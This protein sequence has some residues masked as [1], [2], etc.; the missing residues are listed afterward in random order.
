MTFSDV[1]EFQTFKEYLADSFTSRFAKIYATKLKPYK[2]SENILLEQIYFKEI[3]FLLDIDCK[4]NLLDDERYFLFYEKIKDPYASFT[5]EDFITFKIFHSEV[6]RL[7]KEILS[8]KDIKELKNITSKIYSFSDIIEYINEKIS[9]DARI[10]DTASDELFS[11]REKLKSVRGEITNSINRIF[12]RSDA[13]KFIQ[14]KVIKEYNNR[15]ILLCKTNFKQY[16]NGIVHST[17]G[18]GQTYYVEP[19]SL[20][21]LNNTYQ[22]LV[23]REEEQV[24]KILRSIL[25]KIKSSIFEIVETVEKYSK[26]S[27]IISC[28]KIYNTFKYV[29]PE[30][31]DEII[32]DE[33]YHPLILFSKKEEAVSISFDMR[34]G[35]NLSIITGPNTGG[36][37]AALKTC[38]LNIM[39]AKCG[40][41]LFGKYAKIVNF[42]NVLADIGDNQS[43]IMNL[44]TFSSHLLNIKEII[45]KANSNT[46]VLL[47]ELGTGTE[48]NEGAA[49]ALGVLER[50]INK[51]SKVV[52][53]THF[54]EIKTYGLSRKDCEIYSVDFNYQTFEPSYRLLK[55]VVGKS[56]PII[57][58]KKLNFDEFAIKF[59][60][61][62]LSEKSSSKELLFEE[63]NLF[64]AEL[65]REKLKLNEM[66]MKLLEKEEE[67]RR[68]ET[69]LK[70]K[71]EEKELSLLE[72]TYLLLNKA[73]SILNEKNKQ[74]IKEGITDEEIKKVKGKLDVL[75]SKRS[76]K[77]KI[78][79]GDVVF[80]QKYDKIAKV[81]DIKKDNVYVDLEG[82]KVKLNIN[83][84]IGKKVTQSEA[85]GVKVNKD[86][87]V[88]VR[89]EVVVI[90]KRVEEAI[91]ELDKF[92][93]KAILSNVS[94]IYVVH[95]RGSGALRK[96]IHEYLKNQPSVRSFRVAENNEGGQAVTVVEL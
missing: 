32:F 53:T 76:L 92:I 58:A 60:E 49:L 27:F 91:A 13:D 21:E 28:A 38:G 77:D 46:L 54:S 90:G 70:E 88:G 31:E 18:S 82:L 79:I 65:E 26:L 5:P 2:N 52:V 63:L 64:K 15:Y 48:P 8:N 35:V 71:L 14:E 95:G 74:K 44:S 23:K 96:G 68:K 69:Y 83:D 85:K 42:D 78:G 87:S 67:L 1:L 19:A 43:L 86:V 10:K 66:A 39:I 89:S 36:K 56:N 47:D 33:I 57:V 75:K 22:T 30:V 41:P 51:G 59:A 94:E 29:I 40:L 72:E 20:I 34:K 37:T 11:I 9:D 61:N 16:L 7:K 73:K 3:F 45:K 84:I 12:S 55:S 81:L 4:L 62:Y 80:L 24:N 17:S 93:D 25:E 6:N 50:L